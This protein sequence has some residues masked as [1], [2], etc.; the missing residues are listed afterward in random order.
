MFPLGGLVVI[1][2]QVIIGLLTGR[3][4]DRALLSGSTPAAASPEIPC[5]VELLDF[6]PVLL[7]DMGALLSPSRAAAP[8]P[9]THEN[10]LSG[11]LGKHDAGGVPPS[12]VRFFSLLVHLKSVSSHL[13]ASRF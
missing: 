12:A 7:G 5:C 3:G 2:P 9:V 10:P 6:L 1:P 13:V 8:A 11:L 4:V